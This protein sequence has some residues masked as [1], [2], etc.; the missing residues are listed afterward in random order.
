MWCRCGCWLHI[1]TTAASPPTSPAP[2]ILYVARL[3]CVTKDLFVSHSTGATAA[4]FVAFWFSLGCRLSLAGASLSRRCPNHRFCLVSFRLRLR[5]P[6]SAPQGKGESG[7][8]YSS[9]YIGSMVGDVH[10]TLLYG[11]IFGYP[12]DINNPNGVFGCARM[13]EG[14]E[15]ISSFF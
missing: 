9:R 7:E 6:T 13:I 1:N 14:F 12:G 15:G 3:P 8:K 11:G 10:R 5:P 4:S 2:A